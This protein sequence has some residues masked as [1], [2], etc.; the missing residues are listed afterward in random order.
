M[1]SDCYQIVCFPSFFLSPL[2]TRFIVRYSNSPPFLS[3]PLFLLAFTRIPLEVSSFVELS[4]M[5]ITGPAAQTLYLPPLYTQ[6]STI[7]HLSVCT[8]FLQSDLSHRHDL[9]LPGSPWESGA[10]HDQHPTIQFPQSLKSGREPEERGASASFKHS[11]E[12]RK[13]RD[14]DDISLQEGLGR[15]QVL[16]HRGEENVF[17]L[18]SLSLRFFGL[19]ESNRGAI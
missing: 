11:V 17:D 6:R 14:L 7:P 2:T 3:L 4:C 19:L 1:F 10:C 8:C 12:V 5:F 15:S 16:S 9:Q 18:P 13:A